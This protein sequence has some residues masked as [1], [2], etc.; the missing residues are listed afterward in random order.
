[1]VFAGGSAGPWEVT[2]AETVSGPP[3]P[4][5]SRIEVHERDV[6]P[7]ADPAA[8]WT[9]VG[10]GSESRYTRRVEQDA[11]TATQAPLGRPA[12]GRAV[13]IPIRKSAAW[14]ALAQD[15][16]RAVLAER[17][18]H[19]SIGTR[20]AGTIARRLCHSRDLGGA[21]DFL[22][23]FEFAPEQEPAFDELVAQLRAGPEWSYVERESD[24]RLARLPGGGGDRAALPVPR[25][26]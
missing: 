9:L 15:E 1:M 7:A 10:R 16:R 8:T 26:A 12:A 4:P 3:L 14:W 5:V 21:F 18:R 13:L 23:W 24:I 25:R 20:Y 2:A 11:L 22:T 17:S 6:L 19:I